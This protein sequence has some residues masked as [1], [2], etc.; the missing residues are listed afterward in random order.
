MFIYLFFQR[1]NR[2]SDDD[3]H[4]LQLIQ[5]FHK[6]CFESSIVVCH[7]STLKKNKVMHL[8]TRV[9]QSLFCFFQII[10]VKIRK[11][12]HLFFFFVKDY[13][14]YGFSVFLNQNFNNFCFFSSRNIIFVVVHI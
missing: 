9:L 5:R 4:H 14:F 7:L 11:I 6:R 12:S 3:D 1:S 8:E 2:R 10:L 13:T